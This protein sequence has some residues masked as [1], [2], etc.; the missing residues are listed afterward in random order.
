MDLWTST[1]L[2]C[3][4]GNGKF[5]TIIEFSKFVLVLGFENFKFLSF[6]REQNKAIQIGPFHF[7][8]NQKYKVW[9]RIHV[10]SEIFIWNCCFPLHVCVF[11]LFV[12]FILSKLLLTFSDDHW[13]RGE[14]IL[15]GNVTT[16]ATK[17]RKQ[18]LS[19]KLPFLVYNYK[20][21]VRIV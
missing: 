17:T 10:P 16:K 9:P 2:L 11:S 12:T 7:Y 18:D 4:D 15:L 8:R 19:W 21:I 5:A 14:L 3:K 20:E 1:I 13:G 6:L